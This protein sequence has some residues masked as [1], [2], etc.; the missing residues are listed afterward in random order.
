MRI[1][2]IKQPW[3]SLITEGI[4]TIEVRS[5]PTNIREKIA[6]YATRSPW[7]EGTKEMADQHLDR[8]YLYPEGAIIATAELNNC[9][10]FVDNSHFE[11]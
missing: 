8:W 1:L 10:K 2:A 6:I 5:R 4:K 9:F 7:D 3:A 11:F